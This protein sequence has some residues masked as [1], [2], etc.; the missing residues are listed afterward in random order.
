MCQQELQT[1]SSDVWIVHTPW[2]LKKLSIEGCGFRLI[3]RQGLSEEY[4]ESPGCDYD[5]SN[6]L[7]ILVLKVRKEHN[8]RMDAEI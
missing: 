8:R 2:F 6:L 7:I 1:R 4:R 5:L 3:I